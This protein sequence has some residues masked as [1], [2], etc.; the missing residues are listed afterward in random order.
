[1]GE[2]QA[3]NGVTETVPCLEDKMELLKLGFGGPQ[4]KTGVIET[5]E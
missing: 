4:F 5:L 3:Q 2:F 1:L